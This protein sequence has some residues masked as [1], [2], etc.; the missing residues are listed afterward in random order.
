MPI[1]GASCMPT[2][3]SDLRIELFEP[4][5]HARDVFSCGVPRLDNYLKLTAKKQQKDD[6]TR[7]YVVVADGQ[8]RVL[9]YH[10]INVGMID[11]NLLQSRPR[12]TPDHG[13]LP[14]LFVGHVAVDSSLQGQGI[15]SILLHHAFEKACL[16]A[17]QAG[18]HAVVLDVLEDGG[19]DAFKRRKLW[20]EAFGFQSFP[21]NPSRMF[22]T[23]KQVRASVT[24]KP[25]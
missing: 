16:I 9:G 4:G 12:G 11:A 20:Y 15:G 18:C 17:E 25:L 1:A 6:M 7:V 10:A 13:D 2:E 24:T 5:R 19:N 23:M 14:I 22:M 8:S 21:S 3:H